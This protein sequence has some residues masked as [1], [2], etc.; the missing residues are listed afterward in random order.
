MST[1]TGEVNN[2]RLLRPA[3]LE[4]FLEFEPLSK[5][6]FLQ[7]IPGYLRQATC[8]KEGAFLDGIFEIINASV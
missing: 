7:F 1:K 6:E 4:A 8:G 3:M 5:E 2:E